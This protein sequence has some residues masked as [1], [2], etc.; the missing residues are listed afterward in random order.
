MGY[1]SEEICEAAQRTGEQCNRP[2]R[3][4]LHFEEA[5]KAY[6]VIAGREG[7]LYAN[8]LLQKGVV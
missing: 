7:S 6:A 2:Y 4:V 3:A 8:I 1:V 5:K